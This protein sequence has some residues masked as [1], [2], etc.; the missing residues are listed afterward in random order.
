MGEWFAILF[1]KTPRENHTLALHCIDRIVSLEKGARIVASRTVRAEEE[2]F[3]DHFTGFA[4]LPGVL[5]LEGM[6]QSAVWYV[7]ACEGFA[8]S[9]V[10]M[11]ACSQ[12]KYSKLVRPGAVLTFEVEEAGREG[13]ERE[14]KGKV[15]EEGRS[16]ATARFKLRSEKV[17]DFQPLFSHLEAPLVEKHRKAFER[18]C[19]NSAPK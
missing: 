15:T 6:V 14:F 9:Q 10:F 5:M 4:V 12:A 7:R 1:T 3:Q 11:T 13:A 19:G 2:Y 16:V 8:H 17:G 18:L